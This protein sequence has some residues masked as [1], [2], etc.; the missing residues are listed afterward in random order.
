[1]GI[2]SPDPKSRVARHHVLGVEVLLA[3]PL[4]E[5]GGGLDSVRAEVERG[6]RPLVQ[7]GP[8]G[9]HERRRARPE[10]DDVRGPLGDRAPVRDGLVAE[11]VEA[12]VSRRRVAAVASRQVHTEGTPRRA[13]HGHAGP[14]AGPEAPPE[15]ALARRG[16]LDLGIQ[17][18][19]AAF[20][21]LPPR[22]AGGR[23]VAEAVAKV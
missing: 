11:R 21:S 17:R 18:R 16:R 15:A 23:R 10:R 22:S 14:E 1:M 2:A 5:P 8:G 9:G 6:H 20:V 13:R 7:R 12:E 19:A 3:P 4:E